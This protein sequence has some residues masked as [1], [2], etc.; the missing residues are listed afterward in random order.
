M[1]EMYLGMFSGGWAIDG[2]TQ[3]WSAH[4]EPALA[5]E[6]WAHEIELKEAG[7][8]R[9]A[10]VALW[11]SG[12]LARPFLCGPVVGLTTWAEAQVVAV[13]AAPESTGFDGPCQ[14]QME[15]WPGDAAVLCTAIEVSLAQAID[16]IARVRRIVWS[17]VRPRWATLLDETLAQRPS[18]SLM[19]CVEEDAFTLLGAPSPHTPAAASA[20]FELAATYAPAPSADRTTAL[21]HRTMLSRDV[22]PEDAWFAR[23]EMPPAGAGSSTADDAS[24]RSRWPGA[25][26][27]SEA[28]AS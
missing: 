6:R 14:V 4:T 16:E 13:A 21:W 26:R 28:A 25:V 11:L 8:W 1:I 2:L 9:K 10:N 17:S 20:G 19:A 7:R 24:R 23:L 12:G 5:L 3:A 27:R 22:Q 18:V 15:E